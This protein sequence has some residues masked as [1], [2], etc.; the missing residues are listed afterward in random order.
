MKTKK[1]EYIEKMAAQLKEWSAKIAELETRVGTVKSD[2]NTEYGKRIHELKDE[3]DK[4]ARNIQ[5]IREASGE[6]WTTL[7]VGLDKAWGEFTCAL[8]GARDKFKK[9]A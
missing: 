4:L 6:A 9:A 3:R 8:T 7:K 2:L 5:E 1:E